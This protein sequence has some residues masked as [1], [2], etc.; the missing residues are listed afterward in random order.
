[1][2]KVLSELYYG[3]I[4]EAE[5]SVADFRESDEFKKMDAAAEKLLATFNK[6]QEKLF[7]EY[8]FAMGGYLDLEKLRTYKNGIKLGFALAI[9]LNED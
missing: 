2:K 3:N 4:N 9:E 5:R 8:F 1:M 7:D 6:E